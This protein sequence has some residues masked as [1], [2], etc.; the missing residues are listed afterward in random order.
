MTPAFYPYRLARVF[1]IP[2]TEDERLLYKTLD[3]L[4]PP[5]RGQD[6]R[7]PGET[8]PRRI[9]RVVQQAKPSVKAEA[10]QPGFAAL[11]WITVELEAEPANQYET[12]VTDGWKAEQG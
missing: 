6:V 11:P 7:L 4:L 3:L 12:A 10:W 8:E 5:Q 2:G 1:P 9:A